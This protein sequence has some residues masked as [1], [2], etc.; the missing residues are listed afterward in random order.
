MKKILVPTD[1]SPL[2][3][4]AL[5]FALDLAK[6]SGSEVELVHF[7]DTPIDAAT[8]EE[9]L[10]ADYTSDFFDSATIRGHSNKLKDIAK[11][12]A[13]S[14][15][16]NTS[17]GGS[18]VVSGSE[19]F[20]KLH[21]IDL[22]VIGADDHMESKD[23]FDGDVAEK[24]MEFLALPVISMREH[25]DYVSL[26]DIV[27]GINLNA[28]KYPKKSVPLVKSVAESFGAKI[29]LTNIVPSLAKASPEEKEDGLRDFAKEAGFTNYDVKVI[30]GKEQMEGLL[31]Y[32]DQI[33]A[34]LIATISD[35][36]PG[37][38]K[39]FRDSWATDMVKATDMP[40]LVLNKSKL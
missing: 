26:T 9:Q 32:A 1:Y 3:I 15:K 16:I 27:L 24:L 2:S 25:V 6:A 29:H 13:S 23:E 34:G 19:K 7:M 33:G 39:F 30:E 11:A 31:L 4:N 17:V 35:A 21:K 20:A 36:K 38:M 10:G 5:D 14:V 40:V 12:R 18:G 8:F 28:E 37:L 22:I